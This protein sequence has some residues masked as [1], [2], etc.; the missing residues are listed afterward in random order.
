MHNMPTLPVGMFAIRP[1]PIMAATAEFTIIVKGKGGHAAMPHRTIDPI[2]I[3][4]LDAG[5][6]YTL[7]LSDPG[8]TFAITAKPIT[9]TADNATKVYGTADPTAFT[10][11]TS[12][13]LVT[14]DAFTGT[15]TRVQGD[16][17]GSYAIQQ[18]TLAL[19]NNYAGNSW[20]QAMLESWDALAKRFPALFAELARRGWSDDDLR[21]LAG[22]NFL[23]AWE[24]AEAVARRSGDGAASPGSGD[25]P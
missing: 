11:T 14:G 25:A 8:E 20:R 22:E 24:R 16:N 15:L 23:R 17:V 1:G 6:N 13:P 5:I 19:S 7:V 10:Y 18:G 9:V 3:G 2:V 21:R 4:S 12:D